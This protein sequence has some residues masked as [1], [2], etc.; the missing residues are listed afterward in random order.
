MSLF[1]FLKSSNTE[2]NTETTNSNNNNGKDWLIYF[3]LVAYLILLVDSLF[4]GMNVSDTK[5]EEK[6][7]TSFGFLNSSPSHATNEV[8]VNRQ[9]EIIDLKITKVAATKPVSP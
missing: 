8:I 9:D 3:N 5:E 1:G 7:S 6:I 2:S 4:G